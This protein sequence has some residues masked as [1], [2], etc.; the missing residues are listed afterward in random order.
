LGYRIFRRLN[1]GWIPSNASMIVLHRPRL[2][3]L[4]FGFELFGQSPKRRS[5]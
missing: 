3:D 1:F 5:N 4:M 2:I